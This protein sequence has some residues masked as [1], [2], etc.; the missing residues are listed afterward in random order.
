[1]ARH[2]GKRKGAGRPRSKLPQ[3]VLRKVGEPPIDDPLKL[4]RWWQK[5]IA[6]MTLGVL[7]GEPWKELLETVRASASAAG[8]V[9]PHDIMFEAARIVQADE[10]NMKGTGGATTTKRE[11]K[12]PGSV[13]S[14]STGASRR[15]PT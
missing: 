7:E 3:E 11:Q 14:G 15:D 10:K 13:P 8:R 1:M 9:L 5:A 4:A 12:E 6:V 2:G